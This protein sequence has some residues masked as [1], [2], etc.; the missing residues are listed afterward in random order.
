MGYYFSSGSARMAPREEGLQCV[1]ERAMAQDSGSLRSS[2]Y[3]CDC[4]PG[5]PQCQRRIL[6]LDILQILSWL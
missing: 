1:G 5:F 3:L 2:V 6:R 4:R